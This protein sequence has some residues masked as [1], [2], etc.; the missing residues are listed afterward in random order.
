MF[1][2]DEWMVPIDPQGAVPLESF[3]L[4][5]S[6]APAERDADSVIE[7]MDA[8]EAR[9]SLTA[10]IQNL[11]SSRVKQMLWEAHGLDSKCVHRTI[12][13]SA[14]RVGAAIRRK[15]RVDGF[16]HTSRHGLGLPEG[17]SDRV[18]KFL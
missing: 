14:P 7:T 6:A 18:R 13:K 2:E 10:Y 12:C 16:K 9:A 17:V 1:V 3:E 4:H 5:K 11:D 8:E 15:I